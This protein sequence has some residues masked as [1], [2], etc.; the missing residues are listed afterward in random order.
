[1]KQSLARLAL[2]GMLPALARHPDGFHRLLGAAVRLQLGRMSDDQFREE[3]DA[4][5]RDVD[6]PA[7]MRA[8]DFDAKRDRLDRPG[9][10][11]VP[12]TGWAGDS[13]GWRRR[14]SPWGRRFGLLGRFGIR[15]DVLVL[16]RGGQVPPH[17]HHRVVSGFYV[18]DG[19]VAV[20]HYDRVR[21][22]GSGVVVRKVLDAV[23]GPGGFTT[24]SERHHNIHWLAGRAATSYLF[25]LTV[26]GTPVV[27]FGTAAGTSE[28]VYLDPTGPPD[29]SGLITAPF[30][31]E[32]VAKAIAFTASSATPQAR[33]GVAAP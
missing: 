30:V 20:R 17:G 12:V 24:N 25:R 8:I 14:V 21:E 3:F 23:L 32:A 6:R 1:M 4:Y 18:L 13:T 10:Y 33:A 19:E 2:R 31:T 5:Y 27:P 29:E 26:A 16:R 22:T 9:G 11:K 15:S 7:L 28:R